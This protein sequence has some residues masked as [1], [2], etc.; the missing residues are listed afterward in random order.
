MKK[1]F[2]LHFTIFSFIVF[3]IPWSAVGFFWHL[4]LILQLLEV[5]E[6]G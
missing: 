2:L 3:F 6:L 1:F 4:K 5:D